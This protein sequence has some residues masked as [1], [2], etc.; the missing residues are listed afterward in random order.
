MSID[1]PT[2]DKPEPR[3]TRKRRAILDAAGEVFLRNGYVG[4]SMDEI[5]A[6][7]AVSKQTV[8]KHFTDKA[9]LFHELITETVRDT[10]GA[11]GPTVGFGAG[12]LDEE[13]RAFARH[14]LH[15]VMQP[16]VLQ[17]R[18]LVIGEA[19]R[20]PALGL[21]FHDMGLAAT[22]DT[23]ATSFARLAE[24]G[25]LY[26][27]DPRLAAEHFIWLVLSIPLNRAMLLGDD[28]GVSADDLDHYADAGVSAFLAAY[29]G[30]THRPR[31]ARG[32]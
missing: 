8:Y 23:L 31:R 16:R 17:L 13:L 9:T 3:A 26:V 24:D 6:V 5:A 11:P 30:T 10:D 28:H 25:H 29:A 21:A 1:S 19:T 15:G 7:A 18:R 22:I 12:P 14:F 4:T 2:T 32:R 27:D 20:F